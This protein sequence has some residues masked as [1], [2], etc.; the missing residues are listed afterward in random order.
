[1]IA[2][3]T[4]LADDDLWLEVTVDNKPKPAIA[5]PARYF[6]PGLSGNNYPNYVVLNRNGWTNMLAMPYRSRLA[7]ALANH[8][9]RPVNPVG[10]MVS[11]QPLA[12]ADDPRLAC[13]LRG[14]FETEGNPTDRSWV[15]Q[16]GSG[17]FIGLITQY[18]KAT[19]GVDS[20]VI[21]GKPRDGWHSPDWRC[22]LGIDPK[23]T[24]ERHSLTGRRD[25]LQ[26]RFFLLAPPEFR[27]S[28]DLRGTDGPQLG[29][30][31]ALF[32]VNAR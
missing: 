27:E 9:R 2:A 13:R 7:I 11:Y 29:N 16:S 1:L 19:P 26:W 4:L 12:D 24:D 20:L 5:A 30:R 10:L 14:V 17:R 28:F 15:K 23:A 22:L 18:S 6:F 32:Y 21:D 31:L 8:G 3:P 25:G